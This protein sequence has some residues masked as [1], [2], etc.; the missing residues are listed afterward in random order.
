MSNIANLPKPI[1]N[2]P[3][4]ITVPIDEFANRI[5]ALLADAR[6]A[7]SRELLVALCIADDIKA[8][9]HE[10]MEAT[11]QVRARLFAAH[12]KLLLKGIAV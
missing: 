7:G 10:T 5:G 12:L 9:L 4:H 11:N 6:D 1:G 8:D 2:P 3:E